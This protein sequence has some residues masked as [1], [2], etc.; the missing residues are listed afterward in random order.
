VTALDPRT[1]A[2]SKAIAS[3]EERDK[4]AAQTP[5]DLLSQNESSVASLADNVAAGLLWS[6]D[7]EVGKASAVELQ[8]TEE[9]VLHA[10]DGSSLRKGSLFGSLMRWAF[11]GAL[12]FSL[13]RVL[14]NW[15]DSLGGTM[16]KS[17]KKAKCEDYELPF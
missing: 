10:Q 7:R 16:G 15:Q 14:F 13:L 11:Q 12:L 6:D 9:E 17:R 3:Q 5:E 8:W 1:W 4:I 2:A